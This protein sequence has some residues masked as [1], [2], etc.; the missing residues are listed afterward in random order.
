[1]KNRLLIFLTAFTLVLNC[2]FVL[3]TVYAEASSPDEYAVRL[4][5]ML[6]IMSPA[7]DYEKTIS[8]ADFAVAVGNIFNIDQYSKVSESYFN[9]VP[10]QHWAAGSIN[11][12][13]ETGVISRYHEFRPDDAITGNEAC[14]L[15]LAAAGYDAYADK[16]GGYPSGYYLVAKNAGILDGITGDKK[17]TYA[18]AVN[19]IFDILTLAI[20]DTVE[21]EGDNI[22]YSVSDNETLL[23][24]YKDIYVAEGQLTA[25]DIVSINGILGRRDTLC[26]DTLSCGNISGFDG[27]KFLGEKVRL[28]YTADRDMENRSMVMLMPISYD[29]DIV[30]ITVDK[31]FSFNEW[32]SAVEYLPQGKNKVKSLKIADNAYVVKNGGVCSDNVASAFNISKGEVKLVD[33]DSN[34]EYDVVVIREYYDF[35][36]GYID[37]ENRMIYDKYDRTKSVK[38]EDGIDKRV[39]IMSSNGGDVAFDDITNLDLITVYDSEIYAEAYIC[40]GS[41]SGVIERI[42]GKDKEILTIDG[43]EYTVDKD[44]MEKGGITF[45]VGHKR[46]FKTDYV[47]NIA[48]ATDVTGS[49][50]NYGYL[51]AL[52]DDGGVFETNPKVRIYN[53][54]IGIAVYDLAERVTVDRKS[55]KG[56]DEIS[57][58]LKNFK[59]SISGQ[60]IGYSLNDKGEIA[61]LD[62][63]Y[64]AESED[65]GSLI[66]DQNSSMQTYYYETKTFGYKTIVNSSTV[67][68]AVP[69]DDKLATA[70]DEDFALLPLNQFTDGDSYTVETYKFSEKEGFARYMVAKGDIN[71]MFTRPSDMLMVAGMQKQIRGDEEVVDV[72]VGYSAG[73]KLE[74]EIAPVYSIAASGIKE[75]DLIRYTRNARGQIVDTEMIYS[76]NKELT[77]PEWAPRTS[78]YT[79]G[80]NIT[81][82]YVDSITNDD[83]I[84]IRY[85]GSATVSEVGNFKNV[86]TIVVYDPDRVTDPVYVAGKEVLETADAPGA[87]GSMVFIRTRYGVMMWM[88]M[89]K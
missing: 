89:Y 31:N 14:K 41:F 13:V 1:M 85:E 38:L 40:T 35:V 64:S 84:R 63:A 56:F 62:T 8:R 47:G 15:L 5:E 52:G 45:A 11:A 69:T 30:N 3:P 37:K 6:D 12:L 58:A 55:T 71:Q 60:F 27:Y 17:L 65:G 16:K 22:V 79:N 7:D 48:Y 88:A 57:A 21:F 29:G 44:Y 42:S 18:D 46:E 87:Q 73:V 61:K 78:S 50:D 36:V 33:F 77:P 59:P 66:V 9:D 54:G 19:A 20:F 24:V 68:F 80:V 82:G 51:I 67:I 86:S 25:F 26:V 2:F 53:P 49:L 28:Y 10:A 72:L 4:L 74:L 43:T 34:G 81:H 75:G 23:S 32:Q 70:Q 39:R 76:Y 83:V